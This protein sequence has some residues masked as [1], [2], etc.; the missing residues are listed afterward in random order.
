MENTINYPTV[1]VVKQVTA[2]KPLNYNEKR[3]PEY[4]T[5]SKT[6]YRATLEEAE[7]LVRKLAAENKEWN[8][9]GAKETDGHYWW[10]RT[11]VI[12]Y[13]ID[14]CPMV[15]KDEEPSYRVYD[16]SATLLVRWDVRLRTDD[17]FLGIDREVQ[18][19]RFK[20]GD[21][22]EVLHGDTVKL[23]IVE[24]GF[25]QDDAYNILNKYEDGSDYY[26]PEFGLTIFAPH[27][28][29]PKTVEKSLTTQLEKYSLKK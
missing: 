26:R 6:W 3:Y 12:C 5:E 8:E 13:T 1:F 27:F 14:E 17:N 2:A 11:D 10:E 19:E 22:V 15:E 7:A 28:P 25:L 9:H 24:S 18:K 21:F 20:A 16:D 29:V 23:G 4:K